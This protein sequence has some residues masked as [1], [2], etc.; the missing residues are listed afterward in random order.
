MLIH[1]AL[2]QLIEQTGPGQPIDP[3][4]SIISKD[5]CPPPLIVR[6]TKVRENASRNCF[7]DRCLSC[8][9]PNNF[10]EENKLDITYKVFAVL[11]MISFFLMMLLCIFFVVLPSQ[12]QNH[13]SKLMLLPL[14]LSVMCFEGAEFF[15]I[16]QKQSQCVDSITPA[17]SDNPYCATQAFFTLAGS[18]AIASYSSLL[19][20]HLHLVSVWRIE[21]ITTKIKL[22]HVI[23]FIGSLSAFIVPYYTHNIQ[24]ANICFISLD[25]APAYFY[26]LFFIY[27]AFAAH[28][29]TF[30]YMAH[31]TIKS[32]RHYSVSMVVSKRA[33]IIEAQRR[34]TYLNAIFKMQWRALLG[35]V[36]MLIIYVLNW[37]FYVFGLRVLNESTLTSD[38]VITWIR[39]L[40]DNG[41]QTTCASVIKDDIP[42][43]YYILTLLL[44]N[45]TAGIFIFIIFAAKKSV[46]LEVYNLISGKR[47]R[48][49]Q[50]L[51]FEAE[52]TGNR[53]TKD[54]GGSLN[55]HRLN[56]LSYY[57]TN[58]NCKNNDDDVS[59]KS[60]SATLAPS[61]TSVSR[62]EINIEKEDKSEPVK[63]ET[64][65]TFSH[66]SPT[67]RNSQP[68]VISMRNS[69]QLLST[70]PGQSILKK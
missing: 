44:F 6:D 70:P 24:A 23:I 45:R 59:N 41:S 27:I 10:Y 38:W 36:L 52:L 14:A 30:L 22:F 19:M 58:N 5:N 65:I 56:R 16:N 51:S 64:S 18:F 66:S 48:D 68:T 63:T 29:T 1:S 11:G 7:N 4:L 62:L 28:L 15:T 25:A 37:Y 31:M 43:Y 2:G 39:C 67:R 40:K 20:T 35:A 32:N 21:F 49:L 69:I 34:L 26:F 47:P 3:T 57:M 46:L 53:S 55:A 33:T 50:T 54:S 61:E 9:F 8:P 12:K 13:L 42:S 17:N 60:E